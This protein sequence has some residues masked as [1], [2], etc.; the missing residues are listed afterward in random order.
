MPRTTRPMT[1]I[2]PNTYDVIVDFNSLT[3][4]KRGRDKCSIFFF[5]CFIP[6]EFIRREF[7]NYHMLIDYQYDMLKKAIL[8][9]DILNQSVN[10]H[11]S[12]SWETLNVDIKNQVK[13]NFELYC[14]EFNEIA[15]EYTRKRAQYKKA[16]VDI[17][18]S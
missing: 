5:K 7:D 14:R 18:Q 4:I 16:I 13:Y 3:S 11:I 12:K 17:G 1:R 10:C 9:L 2:Q 8:A 15:E 6:E